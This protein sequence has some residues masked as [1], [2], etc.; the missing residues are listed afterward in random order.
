MILGRFWTHCS[1]TFFFFTKSFE[2]NDVFKVYMSSY[3]KF[4]NVNFIKKNVL[5][6]KLIFSNSDKT[7][8]NLN[9]PEKLP[10]LKYKIL[11]EISFFYCVQ[12]ESSVS[13][14]ILYT[15]NAH[16]VDL[17]TKSICMYL[18]GENMIFWIVL[19]NGECN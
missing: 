5:L 2:L 15:H 17:T 3:I 7:K 9:L 10:I 12:L 14:N 18:M 16:E 4:Y 6:K 19:Y 1:K 13:S 11:S 8:T